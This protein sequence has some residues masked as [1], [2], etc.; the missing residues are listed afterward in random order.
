MKPVILAIAVLALA[1]AA[2]AQEVMAPELPPG[3]P[4]KI[5]TI[6]GSLGGKALA[7]ETFDFSVGAFDASAWASAF[8]G[9]VEFRLRGLKPGSP[10]SPQGAL[11]VSADV[12]PALGTGVAPGP[13]E[14]VIYRNE[15]RRDGA[16]MT[17]AGQSAVVE[18]TSVGPIEKDSYFRHVT[19]RI[20]ARLCPAAWL[21]RSCQDFAARFDTQ[22]QVDSTLPVR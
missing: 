1:G 12:G 18:I 3:Y 20:T 13:V 8:D 11:W 15:K 6:N 22:V 21:G 7:W 10:K 5:G 19:G 9:K 14:V 17:S 2:S 4:P 16:R